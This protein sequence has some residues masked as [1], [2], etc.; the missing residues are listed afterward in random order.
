M[1]SQIHSIL[2]TFRYYKLKLRNPKLKT[3]KNFHV[4]S[5]CKISKG[6]NITIGNNF[7][8]GHNCYLSC[9]AEIGDDVM[10]AS[11]VAL[12]G[13]DHS[14]NDIS[15]NMN[16]APR[17]VI[18]PIKIDSNVWV[19]HGAIVLHGV[20]LKNGCVVGAGSVITKDV[21]QNA[22]VAGN[23]AKVIRYRG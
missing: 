12:I 13:G 16:K 1:K 15:I 3:G 19:G 4:A 2:S 18:K 9:H 21:P 17:D 14:I 20:H 6:R 10:F 7:Y 23:P 11:Q 5:G 22:I 8:M